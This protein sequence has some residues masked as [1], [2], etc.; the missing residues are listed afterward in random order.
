ME[1][2]KDS[3]PNSTACGGEVTNTTKQVSAT[4][5]SYPRI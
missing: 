4:L 3:G 5:A 2:K 1:L